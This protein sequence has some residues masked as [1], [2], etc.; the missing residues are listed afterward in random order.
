MKLYFRGSN[1]K[2]RLL[3]K[4]TS[5]H[6]VKQEID[7]FLNNHNFKSYY[8]RI[9][10]DKKTNRFI[11]DVGSHTEFFEVEMTQKEMRNLPDNMKGLIEN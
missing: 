5:L 2:D 9:W 7:E 10:Y 11:Y 1:Q 3:S 4:C 8:T 6:E